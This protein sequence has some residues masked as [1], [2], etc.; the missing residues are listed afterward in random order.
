M[1][2]LLGLV[3]LG[4]GVLLSNHI[5]AAQAQG[6]NDPDFA[7]ISCHSEDG[8][9]EPITLPSGETLVLQIATDILENSVHGSHFSSL[10]GADG[11]VNCIDCHQNRNQY[12]FP[13]EPNPAQNRAEFN[14]DIAPAC[15]SCHVS[16]QE[17]NPG[18]LYSDN[19]NVPTCTDCHSSGH[20]IAPASVFEAD[21]VATCE[22]CHQDYA[23][24]EVAAVHEQ[25]VANLG[26][27]QDCQTC[28]TDAWAPNPNQSCE[29]CHAL[30]DESLTLE[31]G[32]ELPLRVETQ[33]LRDSVHGNYLSENH[34]ISPLECLDCHQ[35]DGRYEFPHQK[36]DPMSL[37]EFAVQK[38][39]LCETCH[40]DI[41]LETANGI[42]GMALEA[43][44]LDA[45][46][47]V[48][49]HGAHDTP[50]AD[51]PRS[52][53]SQTCAQC[54]SEINEVY[55]MSVHGEALLEE[56]NPDVPV[57]TDCHGVHDIADPTTA[58]FRV[59]SPQLC[60]T[61]HADEGLMAEYDISTDVFE[62]YVADFHGT[63][64][65]LFEKQSPDHET[66]KAVCYD[67]HGVHDILPATAENSPIMKNNLLET[68]RSCH[69]DANAN[70]PD[71]WTSHFKPSLE[72]NPL[73]YLI[74]LFY[75]VVI[76]AT[77][78]GILVFITVDIY[79]R[80]RRRK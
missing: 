65:T 64:V 31:S 14:A 76:P 49:C 47:C 52:R 16:L 67:C 73:I 20:D 60:A 12:R 25:V 23:D 6:P 62:T 69:P 48:D 7:C 11:G 17:H 80:F 72:N 36:P 44:N 77:I 19:P 13:H 53:I 68:C 22:S 21:P 15:E 32:D 18:H 35:D 66:N 74:D 28:H 1:M 2:I 34:A 39:V 61:C 56:S 51:E 27:G 24:P 70:F 37:R 26:A 42:H 40:T 29:T 8:D 38:S 45:A 79:G 54:H 10:D 58:L 9:L 41:H 55:E 59:R 57:C 71:T 50:I 43:G 78:G 46:T 5:N 75:L 4:L 33:T 30:L 3:L 63:T